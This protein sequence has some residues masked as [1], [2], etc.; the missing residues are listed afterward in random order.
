[1][2]EYTVNSIRST[3]GLG[4]FRIGAVVALAFAAGLAAWLIVGRGGSS[5]DLSPVKPIAA[6]ALSAGGLKT[7]ADQVGQPVYWAGTKAGSTYEFSRASNDDI[8]VRYLPSGTAVGK[9]GRFLIIGTYRLRDAYAAI[10]RASR[11]KNSVAV[12]LPHGRLAVYSPLRPNAYYFAD[13]GSHYQV[14]VFAPT[15]ALARKL[16]LQGLVT[17][18]R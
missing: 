12:K 9:K 13:K 18:V 14:G 3:K 17:P 7:M 6:T 11:G 8:F 15:A 2:N 10:Q 1:M 16:V 5:F 4:R